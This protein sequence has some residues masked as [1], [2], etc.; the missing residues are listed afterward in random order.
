MARNKKDTTQEIQSDFITDLLN[1][2]EFEGKH[3]G[4][5]A[6]N[7]IIPRDLISTGSFWFDYVLQGGYRSG[8]WARVY[9]MPE[10][11]KTSLALCWGR[12]WQ[13]F[14]ED[15]GFVVYFNAEGR[16]NKELIERTGINTNPEKFRIIDSNNAD[17]IYTFVER[18]LINN[19]ENKKY[20]VIIDSTDACQRQQ[21]VAKNLGEAEKI[22]GGATIASAAGKRLSLLFDRSNHFLFL[23]SQVRDKLNTM[24]PGAGGKDASGGN[25]PKFYSSLTFEI[26]NPWTET[27]IYENPS[28]KK[29]NIIGK[30]AEFKLHKTPNETTGKIVTVPIKYGLKGGVWRAYEMMM[31]A[32]SW[33]MF[34]KSGTW[35]NLDEQFEADLKKNNIEIEA[36]VQGE[37]KLRD[38]FDTNTDLV[39]YC[40]SRA[41]QMLNGVIYIAKN[42]EECVSTT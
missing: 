33:N 38:L 32:Q 42:E 31:A 17:F 26:K 21:D 8:T 6:G 30:L 10:N 12:N 41:Q 15:N 37:R 1:S 20:F 22:G 40:L 2:K 14:Y 5:R 36:K 28:D 34:V 4:Q 7:E 23:C 18:L 16:I 25:A 39:N 24:T 19:T 35:F 11:G 13:D 27:Y 29:S 3:Y 9:S